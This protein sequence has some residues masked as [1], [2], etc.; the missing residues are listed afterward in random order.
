MYQ[1]GQ[2]RVRIKAEECGRIH[3]SQRVA[4]R[5]L[6]KMRWPPT[7]ILA[8]QELGEVL[9]LSY[10]NVL[11][12]LASDLS[13][14]GFGPRLSK[15]RIIR[16]LKQEEAATLAGMD[17]TTLMKRERSPAVPAKWMQDKYKKLGQ[18]LGIVDP[19]G[20]PDLVAVV[21]I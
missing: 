14:Q 3:R 12:R 17:P 1:E 7:S 10:E 19:D 6:G 4:H 15:A 13:G 21:G 2:S 9:H 18:V 16:A 5:E 11:E 8:G 20:N